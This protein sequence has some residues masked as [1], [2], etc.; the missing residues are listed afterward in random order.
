MVAPGG[1]V[2]APLP[3][4]AAFDP[5][6][7]PPEDGYRKVSEGWHASK[8]SDDWL[9]KPASGIFYHVPTETFWK[10]NPKERG[11]YLQVT[12]GSLSGLTHVAA[13]GLFGLCRQ[14]ADKVLLR[15]CFVHWHKEVVKFTEMEKDLADA[16]D[17]CE[18]SRMACRPRTSPPCR[19]EQK[20]TL[21][22][23]EGAPGQPSALSEGAATG[24]LLSRLFAWSPVVAGVPQK[25][26]A[27]LPLT[28]G[29]LIRLSMQPELTKPPPKDFASG[30]RG[31]QPE[32]IAAV[33]KERCEGWRRHE[34][35]SPRAVIEAR[36]CVGEGD[37]VVFDEGQRRG[38]ITRAYRERDEYVVAVEGQV[39][40]NDKDTVRYFKA[41]E[42]CLAADVPSNPRSSRHVETRD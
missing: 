18:E 30:E 37:A 3:G 36:C 27:I 7:W 16:C 20:E 8:L 32:A 34:R 39:V 21:R 14:D 4:R 10:R 11:R 24:G 26:P 23:S 41:D 31:R 2:R 38:V 1:R 19:D 25:P 28:T 35:V 12:I 6:T 15:A 9:Y 42:M 40:K 17:E 29:T 22:S 33:H 13:L 5:P